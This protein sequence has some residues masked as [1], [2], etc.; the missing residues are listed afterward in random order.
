MVV[1]A[2]AP[3]ARAAR[4]R[5]DAG[6]H[7][8]HGRAWARCPPEVGGAA[9][10]RDRVFAAG[11]RRGR[12]TDS[13]HRLEPRRRADLRLD[14][15]RDARETG[16]PDGAGL[17]AR[18]ARGPGRQAWWRSDP[19]RLR[20]RAPAQG[21]D[22]HRRG[23]RGRA[24]PRRIRP[25]GRPDGHLQRHQR[26][27]ASGGE[28][29]GGPGARAHRQLGVGRAREPGHL[30]GRDVSPVGARA[31]I[32]GDRLRVVPCLGPSGRSNCHRGDGRAGVRRRVLVRRRAPGTAAGRLGALDLRPR[33]GRDRRVGRAASDARHG[34]GH[35]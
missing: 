30:V 5:R 13:H 15:G 6:V 10:C 19:E 11:D 16:C 32:G 17:Q 28:A 9:A 31:W 25:C 3:L 4:S 23:R 29:R 21:R 2:V 22:A 12:P 18:R 34:A 26:A 14:A 1:E 24:G 7:S 8:R 20:D 33:A 35:H 27:Q